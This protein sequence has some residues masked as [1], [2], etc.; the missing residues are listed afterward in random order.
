MNAHF[1]SQDLTRMALFDHMHTIFKYCGPKVLCAQD[2]LGS[3]KPKEMTNTFYGM[4]IIQKSLI[5][6]MEK[7]STKNQINPSM[8]KSVINDEVFFGMMMYALTLIA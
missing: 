4:E 5:L 7:E 2:I 6:L 8:I 3:G 1:S